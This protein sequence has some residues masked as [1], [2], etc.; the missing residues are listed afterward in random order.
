MTDVLWVGYPASWTGGRARAP[1]VVVLHYTAGSEGPTSAE[2]GADYDKRRTD[3]TSTH[4]FT[5]SAGPALQEVPDGDRAHTARYHGNEIGIHIEICG[6]VQNRSQWLDP[7]SYATLVTTAGLVAIL[8]QRHGFAF[9]R[10]DPSNRNAELRRAYYNDR[11]ITGI[12]DHNACTEAFPEDGGTHTDVGVNFPWDV[13][14][15]LV[16]QAMGGGDMP[17]LFQVNDGPDGPG[18]VYGSS[19]T[20]RRGFGGPDPWG[21]AQKWAKF[22]GTP[23]TGLKVVPWADVAEMLGPDVGTLVNPPPGEV[24]PPP[25]GSGVTEE[26]AYAIARSVVNDATATTTIHAGATI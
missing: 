10:L 5:D 9:R 4:Y 1:Q 6:T 13:F 17:R 15:D 12:V 16:S 2:A 26:Q 7:T 21:L 18:A 24:E 8:L 19:G 3:G 14:M 22:W 20:S 23:S 25:P 11:S